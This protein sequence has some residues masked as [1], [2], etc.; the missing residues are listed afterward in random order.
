MNSLDF[1]Y[2]HMASTARLKH[3]IPLTQ[4]PTEAEAARSRWFSPLSEGRLHLEQ[5]TWV[6]AMVPWRAS[7]DGM[8]TR[9]VLD[10]V[11]PIRRRTPGRPC[12]RGDG[13]ARRPERSAPAHRSRSVQARVRGSSRSSGARGRRDAPLHPNHRLPLGEA[14]AGK[15]TWVRRFLGSAMCTGR[16]SRGGAE[17]PGPTTRSARRSSSSRT[18]TA[19]DPGSARAGG[20]EFGYRERVTDPDLPHV[21]ELP[22]VL[23]GS[24]PPPR[25]AQRR[26]ASTA[27]SSTSRTR[28]RWRGSSR[29]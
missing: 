20:L 1:N 21:R 3:P 16:V 11:R 15:E 29:R 2:C 19:R 10:V 17:R 22:R 25:R 7:D 23:P 26:R 13:R 12:R 9:E 5:R 8:V 28:T 4:W 24:S 27:S 14:P 6:P 18:R